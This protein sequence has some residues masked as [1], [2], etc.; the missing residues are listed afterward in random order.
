MKLIKIILEFKENISRNLL[1]KKITDFELILIC[2]PFTITMVTTRDVS[3]SNFGFVITAI[4]FIVG[5]IIL[6]LIGIKWR[7]I[8]FIILFSF[9]IFIILYLG[10]PWEYWLYSDRDS[11][12]R[13]GIEAI[14]N[15][16]NPYKA[17][18]QTGHKVNPFPFTFLFYLPL[19]LITGGY[20]FYMNLIIFIIFS[21]IIYFYSFNSQKE[22]TILPILSFII[23]SD[24]FFLETVANSDLIN[25]GF[26]LCLLILLLPEEIPEQ[27]PII[28]IFKVIP[29]EP[30]RINK[31]ILCFSIFFGCFLA[32]RAH[33]LLI[34]AII[35]L[36]L[37]KTH[38]FKNTLLL[39]L[40]SLI[41]AACIILPFMLLDVNYFLNINPL[42]HN[43]HKFFPWRGYETVHPAG[44]IILDFLNNYLN[45]NELN[46]LI[47]SLGIIIFSL[48]LGFIK[49]ENVLHLLFIITACFL[50]FIFFY[51]FGP[52]YG[53][54][55]DYVSMATIPLVFS[56]YFFN[57]K[58]S[59]V[60]NLKEK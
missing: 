54:V 30:I 55:R 12:I 18:T 41:I 51:F 22:L 42:G 52:D 20:T 28:K 4:F 36:Y 40:I 37:L 46:A 39:T 43:T 23:F 8:Y 35:T 26:L 32:M 27:K 15:G 16:S 25:S 7:F 53:L 19:Y 24:W 58:S 5:V 47:I 59:I 48:I 2:V 31:K 50:I 10:K 44:Y 49:L 29:K 13:A 38:G 3:L 6:Y 14:L 60:I 57:I 21:I 11:Q 33:F 9:G 56:F 17:K 45:Y 34:G 1:N